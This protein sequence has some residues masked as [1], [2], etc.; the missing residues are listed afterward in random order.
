MKTYDV[1]WELSKNGGIKPFGEIL[2][3]RIFYIENVINI[4]FDIS[5]ARARLYRS[6]LGTLFNITF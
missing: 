5:R 1:I 6:D 3:L 4:G 2:F